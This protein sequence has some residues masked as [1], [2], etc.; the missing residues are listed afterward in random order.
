MDILLSLPEDC[1]LAVLSYLST[2]DLPRLPDAYA[3]K[4]DRVDKKAFR[5]Q[6]LT[7]A[8]CTFLELYN[9]TKDSYNS[10]ESRRLRPLLS[11]V[12]ARSSAKCVHLVLSLPVVNMVV[13]ILTSL[14]PR[15]PDYGAEPRRPKR[16]VRV[17][18]TAR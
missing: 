14:C 6:C 8:P 7:R 13:V 5:Q 10:L 16:R 3:D 1:R 11:T 12:L 17:D 15:V 9:V 18:K 2:T 4:E